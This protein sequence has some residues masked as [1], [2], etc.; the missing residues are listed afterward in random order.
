MNRM[1]EL[2]KSYFENRD[3]VVFAFLY[4]AFLDYVKKEIEDIG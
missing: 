1:I 3:D 4:P 2:L